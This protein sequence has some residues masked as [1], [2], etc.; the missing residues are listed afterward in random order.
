MAPRRDF[1]MCLPIRNTD[2]SLTKI[3]RPVRPGEELT[4]DYG[5][6]SGVRA[7]SLDNLEEDRHGDRTRCLCGTTKCRGWMP[8]D[9]TL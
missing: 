5:D 2:P 1:C 9:E 6:A 8:F 7:T 4:F 3:K